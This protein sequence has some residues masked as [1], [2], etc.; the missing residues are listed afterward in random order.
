[1]QIYD[2]IV[3]GAG[4]IGSGVL[5]HLARRGVRVLGLDQHAPAHGYGSSHGE[6]RI[7]RTAYFEHPDYVPLLRRAYRLWDELAAVRERRL[8]ERVGLLQVGPPTGE[9][10]Q[11]VLRSAAAHGLTVERFSSREVQNTF[12]GFVTSDGDEAVFERDAGYLRV[13]W[14]VQAHLAEALRAGAEYRSGVRVDSWERAESDFLVCTASETFRARQ[15]VIAAGPWAGRLLVDLGV[16][17]VVLRKPVFWFRP[18]SPR[19][20][21][22]HAPTF[23]YEL[24]HGVFYGFPAIDA[25]GLKV[26]EHSGGSVVDDPAA[27][28]RA[29]WPHERDACEQFL[30]QHLPQ[31]GRDFVRQS[32][33]LYTMS[34]DQH[35][36]VDQHPQHAGLW[37]A[38]GFSGH[39]F[40]FASVLGEAIAAKVVD[41]TPPVSIDFLRMARLLE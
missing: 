9:V 4:G 35:F 29:L 25:Q 33:C 17:L 40:K 22:P 31:V 10:V 18:Q 15:L 21:A 20:A 6:T 16:P 28:D 41:E 13:E 26:G 34:P 2:V 11:G 37:L 27:V 14:C 24:P 23:L 3:I 30:S 7:I 8:F 38:A 19:Y 39:G 1:M 32:V 12:P 36:L 5:C